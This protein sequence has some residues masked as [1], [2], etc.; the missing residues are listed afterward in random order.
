MALE[1]KRQT[2]ETER[3]AGEASVQ[4]LVRAEAI[5][6]GAGREAV[7]LLLEE[8]RFS[9]GTVDVQTDRV[10]VDALIGAQALYRLGDEGETRALEASAPVARAIELP[11]A[12]AG[13][14]CLCDGQIEHI[15]AAYEN[16]HIVFQIT[17][18]LRVRVLQLTQ[19]DVLADITGEEGL[20]KR[21]VQLDSVKLSAES[22][23]QAILE[24]DARMPAV[25][26]ARTA[27]MDWCSVRI[28][29]TTPDLGGVKVSGAVLAEALV[30]SGVPGR[31]VAIVKYTLPFAQLVDLPE[32]LCSDTKAEA[33]V[34]R[35]DAQLRQTDEGGM[36]LHFD[37]EVDIRVLA[38][39]HDSIGVLADAYGTGESDISCEYADISYC[40]GIEPIAH[41]ESI[42]A[43]LL[44]AEGAPSA[45]TVIAVRIR[46]QLGAPEPFEGGTRISG[47]LE[48]QVLYLA[49]GS[50]SLC[51]ARGD[52]PFELRCPCALSEGDDISLDVDSAD[53][54]ALTNDRLEVRCALRLRGS[55][56]TECACRAV[57]SARAVPA[58]E[59]P[60][61][62][63]LYWPDED[64]DMWEIGRRY[65]ISAQRLKS[66]N[67]QRKPSAPLLVRG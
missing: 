39:G 6:P 4:L 52:L 27:L 34:R 36:A 57:S 2:I 30:G 56:R 26:D 33:H 16:G 25:L 66:L 15:E 7:T 49:T 21:T 1:E 10:V 54:S 65:R 3:T 37:A 61:G 47:L 59:E 64:E 29:E 14:S 41:S 63:T 58:P 50:G 35:L 23:A 45:G 9:P 24:G 32:W 28:D 55:H 67:A 44:L 8:A 46:P 5:V 62:V 17:L 12:A 51:R 48:T 13:M 40:A 19:S 53:A 11:G 20:E 18:G 22:S 42:R 43:G 31:P 60:F 38:Y